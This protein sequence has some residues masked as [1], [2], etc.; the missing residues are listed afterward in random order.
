M[1]MIKLDGNKIEN[2]DGIF[3]QL[4]SSKEMVMMVMMVIMMIIMIMAKLDDNEIEIDDDNIRI[5]W[6]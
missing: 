4:F 3:F 6:L 2:Y 1:M 5:L